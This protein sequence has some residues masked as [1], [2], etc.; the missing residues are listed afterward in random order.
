MQ[1]NVIARVVR[2]SRIRTYN[3]NGREGQ[4]ITLDLKDDTGSISLTLWNKDVEII[5]EIELKEG[6]SIK[7]LGA[8]S[9][10]RNDEVNLTHS[11]IGRI[12]KDNFDVPEYKEEVMKI[13]DA[14]EMKDVALMGVVSKIQDA[15][16]FSTFRWKCGI[17]KIN[18]NFR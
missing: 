16:T 12:I 9:R 15:I 6:D 2:I 18:C 5:N 7:I 8:Q 17:C 3:S 4:F 11:W 13:G 14:H 10:V 1:V